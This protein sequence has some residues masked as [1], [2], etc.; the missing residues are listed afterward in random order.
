MEIRQED[1]RSRMKTNM[2][3]KRETK[4]RG[5][6]LETRYSSTKSLLS[7]T[8]HTRKLKYL[9][10]VVSNDSVRIVP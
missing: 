1:S 6:K 2:K 10:L 9:N 7:F 4:K 5:K 8:F 3:R